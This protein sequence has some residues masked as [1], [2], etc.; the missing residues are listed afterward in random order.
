[1]YMTLYNYNLYLHDF[2]CQFLF[3]YHLLNLQ[4]S[5]SSERNEFRGLVLA[6]LQK[7]VV[8]EL[9]ILQGEESLSNEA[10]SAILTESVKELFKDISWLSGLSPRQGFCWGI[11]AAF[12]SK[13]PIN[14]EDLGWIQDYDF[15]IS[16]LCHIY[17]AYCNTMGLRGED[18]RRLKDQLPPSITHY[19]DIRTYVNI[20]MYIYLQ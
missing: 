5:I 1:M 2:V 7:E 4:K 10:V 15:T 17:K 18:E 9:K 16:H 6:V 12:C 20:Y 14:A 11:V 3:C 8:P 13:I 19:D